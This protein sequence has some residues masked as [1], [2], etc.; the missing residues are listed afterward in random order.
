MAFDIQMI[1]KAYDALPGR[2]QAARVHL[3]RP[4][5]LTEKILYGHIF[6]PKDHT[7][8]ERIC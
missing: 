3:S 6:D 5:T 8:W 2:I 7:V 4:L 1:L